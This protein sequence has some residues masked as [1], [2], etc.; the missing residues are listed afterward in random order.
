MGQTEIW[1]DNLIE[2]S[3][4]ASN[5]PKTPGSKRLAYFEDC[6]AAVDSL[7]SQALNLQGPAAFDEFLDFVRRFRKLSVFNALLI[8]IQCQG[9]A[10]VATRRKWE[11]LG[12]YVKPDAI[13]LLILQPFGPICL[14]Y[15]VG[16]T[17]GRPIKSLESSS[18]LATGTISEA[19]YKKIIDQAAKNRI[20]VEHS[21]RFGMLLAGT[22]Q[23][24]SILPSVEATNKGNEFHIRL[25]SKHDLPTRFAT[26]AHELGHIYC[27]HCGQDNQGRWPDRSGLS[28]GQVELEAEAV[29]WLVCQRRGIQSRSKEYLS[30]LIPGVDLQKVSMYTIFNAANRIETH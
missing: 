22:A 17:Y 25:N 20:T 10:A 13:P 24:L 30:S 11:K 28:H 1:P 18:L 7:F 6:Q 2:D 5:D 26:L 16:D 27:G 29:A 19:D 23:G 12:R 4:L 3:D 14:V 8:R 9:A 21:D 15:E